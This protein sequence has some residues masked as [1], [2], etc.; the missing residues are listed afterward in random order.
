MEIPLREANGVISLCGERCGALT[1]VSLS[2]RWSLALR[3]A[4]GSN[5][6]HVPVVKRLETLCFFDKEFGAITEPSFRGGPKE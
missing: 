1:Y 5:A 6:N 3:A 4:F 2:R